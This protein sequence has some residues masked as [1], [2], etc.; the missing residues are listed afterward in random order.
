MIK[1]LSFNTLSRLSFL[2]KYFMESV[3][4]AI[5]E[6]LDLKIFW[7]RMP[8]EPP[9]VFKPPPPLPPVENT[10]R[11][12]WIDCQKNKQTNENH[13]IVSDSAHYKLFQGYIS[14]TILSKGN[15]MV[16]WLRP[17]LLTNHFKYVVVLSI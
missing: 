6:T 11:R 8:P 1:Y 2:K 3:E 17:F 7:G 14:K 5:S 12:P 13:Q 16:E 9:I 10:F 4:N 15:S